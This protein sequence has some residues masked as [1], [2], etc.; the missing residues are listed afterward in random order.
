MIKD[1]IIWFKNIPPE[2]QSA[3][4][5]AFTTIL[6]FSI[7]GLVKLIYEKYS[8]NYKMKREYYFEQRKK[9]K[10][11]LSESKTPLIKSAEELNYRLWNLLKHIEERWHN[12]DETNWKEKERYYLRSFTYRL[13]SFFYWTL[14]AEESLYSMD[15]KQADK[16]DA[17]Y[18][19]YIKT[20]K[21]FFCERE[22]LEELG[23]KAGGCTNHF[24]KDDLVKYC[25]F[26][27]DGDKIIDFKTF[28]DKFNKNYDDIKD[29]IIYI[30]NIEKDSTN[31]NYNTTK[32]F[33][34]FLM[35]FL[36]KYGLDY[37]YTDKSKLVGLMRNEYADLKIK[38]GLFLFL[39]RNKVLSES[40]I[41]IK[42]LNLNK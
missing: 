42:N 31:L 1:I 14:K 29:V 21:H 23:Y 18:L 9:I 33:H 27:S 13:I 17:L 40:K 32:A 38:K 41:V 36:N 28:E 5:S 39:E 30:R 6:I 34:L 8:L 16:E 20:L 10:E 19:K 37:H 12:I 3:I 2:T 35:L 22:L 26:L 4:I 15:L 24:Y 25:D 7:G 11:I